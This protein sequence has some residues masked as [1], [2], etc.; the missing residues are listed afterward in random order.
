MSRKEDSRQLILTA[1]LE[2]FV[3]NGYDKTSMDDIVKRS[4]LSKGTLYWHFKNKH[5]LFLATMQMIMGQIDMGLSDLAQQI[6][7]PA[8]ERL[9][10][11]FSRVVAML[12]TDPKFAGLIANAFFQSYQNAEAREIMA[13]AYKVYIHAVEQIVQQGIASGEFRPVDA[14]LSAVALIAG[15]DGVVFYTLLDPEWNL[16]NALSV[17]L[18]LFL[19]GMLKQGANT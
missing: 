5:D 14:Y 17:Q 6:D 10:T 1:A 13:E 9:R 2:A 11:L 15:G 8:A 16:E 18:D 4:G 3:E 7:I 12:E 19:K